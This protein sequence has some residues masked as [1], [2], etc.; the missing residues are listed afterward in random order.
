MDQELLTKIIEETDIVALASEFMSLT[1][2]GKNYMGLCP[3]HDEK[4]PSF[5]V[6]P[7]KHIAKCMGC[8]KG[9]NTVTFYAQIKNISFRDAS[10][11]L[12]ERL[13]IEVKGESVVKDPNE[14]LYLLMEDASSFYQFALKNSKAGESAYNY[15][16][17]RGMSDD[18]IEHFEIGLAPSQS[19]ALYQMLKSKSYTVTDMMNLGLVKQSSEGDY[20]DV[21][22]SRITFPV[23][24]DKNRIV[25]FSA[26]SLLKDEVV[27]YVNSTE[28]KIFKK[29]ELLYHFTDSLRAAVKQ[30]F[31]ILHEGFFDVIAS[32][33]SNL[34]AA[35]ATM[36]TA[37]T[38]DQ[39]KLIKRISDHVVIAYDGD[40]AG[41]LATLKAIPV[42]RNAGLKISVL[43][44]PKKLDPDEYVK[45]HG[46]QAY[47]KLYEDE[48]M[49]PYL[50]G[51]G[52]YQEKK[53]F[54]RADDITLFKKEMRALLSTADETILAFYQKKA[55]EELGIE[56]FL[57]K[58]SYQLPVK[59]R[60]IAKPI[61]SKA[62]R[63]IDLMIITLLK[64]NKYLGKIQKHLDLTN[65]ITKLQKDLY[66]EIINYYAMNKE[67]NMDI[68]K[69][70][71]GYTKHHDQLGKYVDAIEFKKDMIIRNDNE[72]K[73]HIDSIAAYAIQL[74]INDLIYRVNSAPSESTRNEYLKKI[75]TLKKR[76]KVE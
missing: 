12:A 60:L 55:L 34:R 61:V 20:Y 16:K 56:L 73:E 67:E 37:L 18:E 23:K 19:D 49:D 72:F 14:K 21:F 50:F 6:S 69:F 10:L 27:K 38:N 25:G 65:M 13:G 32:Y 35:V 64:N 45:K 17:E 5:S 58:G 52:I 29:G 76:G 24:N 70:K 57:T 28:T 71:Q 2:K 47:Y 46:V 33:R 74:E 36:G 8:G 44:L 9:G 42:L 43:A 30:K 41:R 7:E 63:A 75:E 54:S 15:L 68:E 40:A 31:V 48:L 26:R 4:T 11:E 62:E 66:K 1:K 59:E 22:R 3:F 53:D 51:Y 39:A